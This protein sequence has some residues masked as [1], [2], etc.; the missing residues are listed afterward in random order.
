MPELL[1]GEKPGC[2]MNTHIN[3]FPGV[4]TMN[5]QRITV[6]IVTA[7]CLI[8][9]AGGVFATTP[10]LMNYQGRA[11]DASGDPVADGIHTVRFDLF[12]NATTGTSFWNEQTSVTTS[13]GLFTHV[14]GSVTPMNDGAFRGSAGIWLQVTFDGEIQTPR[15]QFTSVGYA[16]HVESIDNANGGNI[17]DGMA[18][19][20]PYTDNEI[21][22]LTSD[23]NGSSNLWLR[24]G[25]VDQSYYTVN[26]DAATNSLTFIDRSV[27]DDTTTYGIR[28]I[29]M[30]D[31][32][33]TVD[34]TG[35]SMELAGADNIL[36]VDS[37]GLSMELAGAS[38]AYICGVL[39]EVGSTS[40]NGDRVGLKGVAESAWTSNKHLTGVEAY[41]GSSGKTAGNSFGVKAEAASGPGS[42]AVA[43][44]A[45]K[46]GTGSG[47][48]GYFMGDVNI[49]GTLSK[50][51][52]SFKIDH[53]LDPERKYLQHSFVESPD[54]KNI[55]DGTV[56][57]DGSGKAVVTLPDYFSALNRD[58]RYQLTVIG[59]FAQA[60][61]AEEISGNRFVIQTDKPNVKVSWLVTGIRKDKWAEAHRIEVEV[62]KPADEIG[63]YL[64][65]EEFG[66]S[67][68]KGVSW[69]HTREA[70]E[71]RT[72][73]ENK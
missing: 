57:T 34:S 2:Q 26:L 50:S 53:P 13:G 14:F 31:N 58:F 67:Q 32:I 41:A 3:L 5:G 10:K 71:N 73:Q 4:T 38:S 49:I 37:T 44:W 18:I 69:K 22:G 47:Y 40:D 70:R 52:G 23:H 27:G 62:D 51:G 54:M 68:E 11:T 64:H 24:G 66:Q 35:L 39:S 9:A 21:A 61:I 15:T 6:L 72:E 30:V 59:Q 60:I 65:P 33:L 43:L 19:Y 28:S 20:D 36:A 46:Y 16:F 17:N 7:I 56:T 55:Y 1:I 29:K 48:A 12:N 42:Y 25:D 63:T 45:G 8:L